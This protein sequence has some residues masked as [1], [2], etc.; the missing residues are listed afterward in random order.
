MKKKNL[1]L[2]ILLVGTSWAIA[3]TI[4]DLP[5]SVKPNLVIEFRHKAGHQIISLGHDYANGHKET[6]SISKFKYYLSN[7]LLKSASK[8]KYTS[9]DCYLVNEAE[10]LSKKIALNIPPGEYDSIGFLLG[11]DSINNVSGAQSG[12]LDPLNDMFW[13]WNTGYV[14]VKLEGRSPLSKLSQQMIEYHI[15]GFRGQYSVLQR[16]VFPK[17]IRVKKDQ[18]T[19]IVIDLDLLKWFSGKHVLK[20]AEHPSCTSPGALALRYAA[21]YAD[22]FSIQSVKQP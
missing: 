13:T 15:G 18:T 8:T 6:F 12:A 19:V 3:H 17:K 21:N 20:I 10:P 7:F 9:T 2:M 16:I 11:V 5:A 14:M 4:S 1:I 22:M